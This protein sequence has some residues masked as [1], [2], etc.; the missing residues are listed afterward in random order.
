[1]FTRPGQGFFYVLGEAGTGFYACKPP[2]ATL[3]GGVVSRLCQGWHCFNLE[4]RKVPVLFA[5]RSSKSVLA[6]VVKS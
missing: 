1:M 6:R 3:K 5:Y 4:T 2:V